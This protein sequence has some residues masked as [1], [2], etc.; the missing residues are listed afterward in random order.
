MYLNLFFIAKY[1][2]IIWIH[3]NFSYIFINDRYLGCFCLLDIMTNAATDIVQVFVWMNSLYAEDEYF[4]AIQWVYLF[5]EPPNCFPLI[6]YH[7]IFLPTIYEGSNFSTSFSI[8]FIIFLF[9]FKKKF[10]TI[11][12]NV[13]WYL[14]C[15]FDMYLPD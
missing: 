4:W 2:S 1:Y 12:V 8:L 9:F 6:W 11:L 7:F 10:L 14:K 13:N 5:E 15:R 3:H